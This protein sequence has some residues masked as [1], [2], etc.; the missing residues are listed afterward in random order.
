MA[1]FIKKPPS[2]LPN[3]SKSDNFNSSK[4]DLLLIYD[5]SNRYKNRK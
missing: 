2:L 5:S 4:L 3:T 1:V